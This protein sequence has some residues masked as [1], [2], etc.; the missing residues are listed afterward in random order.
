MILSPKYCLNPTIP[1]CY[2]CGKD[3]NEVVLFGLI[4]GDVEAPRN[5]VF[6][7]SPCDQC[8]KYMKYG[9]ILISVKD[10]SKDNE[11][12]YRTGRFAVVR[13]RGIRKTVH[14]KE[15]AEVILQKRFCFV[16]DQVWDLLGLSKY[17]DII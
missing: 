15:L 3:K 6:D 16:P 7:K 10:D 4:R 8:Q 9:V 1:K 5:M 13:D 12:P 2:Y 14:P 11:E 17:N